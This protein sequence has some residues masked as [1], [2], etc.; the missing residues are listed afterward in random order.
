MPSPLIYIEDLHF[1][2]PVV[3]GETRAAPALRGINLTVE[4][5]ECVAIMGATGAGKSTLCLALNGL[6]P[7]STGGTFRGNVW[8]NGHNTC[9]EPVAALATQVGL[10]F[11]EAED[12]LCTMRVEDEIA[13]GLENLGLPPDEI[14]RRITWALD[15]VAMNDLRHHPPAQLS[16]G[17]Q[18]R[19]AL[20]AVLAM[21]PAVLVLDEPTAGLDPIGRRGVLDVVAAL[22]RQGSTIL[23]ATQD[24]EAAATLAD[25]VVV[26]HEGAIVLEGTPR[27]VFARV[28]QL[29]EWGVAVPQLSA[30]SHRLWCPTPWMT[31]QEAVQG[32][33]EHPALMAALRGGT[34][35]DAPQHAGNALAEVATRFENVWY[36]YESG[37]QA[38]QAIDLTLSV[39][40]Y[41]A[42]IGANGSG[43]STLARHISGLLRPQVGRVVVAGLDTRHTPPGALARYVGY[44][45]QNP[46][47]QIFSATVHEEVAFGPRNLGLSETQ[48]RARVA[49][50]LEQFQLSALADVPP[51]M[52]SFGQ[53]RLVTLASVHAMQPRVLVL[54]E[55]TS[56]LDDKLI[57]SLVEWVSQCHQAGSTVLFITHE[58]ALA[59]RAARCLVMQDGQIALDAPP[60]QVFAQAEELARVGL[61]PPP[62]V[63]LGLQLGLH[64]LPLTVE[65]FHR[66]LERAGQHAMQEREISGRE[67]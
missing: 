61:A 8:V 9:T 17:Q 21:Q 27:E 52:L 34:A 15:A 66:L 10:V 60:A 12:Q 32:L 39:G 43:K 19:L 62:V 47:H 36:R 38:L 11:Q 24:A 7:Q 26:L 54:D 55:P 14:E 53:R 40:E 1:A 13:F 46:D 42:L 4:A 33:Q 29:L 41:V 64:P 2:Y 57:R 37:V 45:F 28:P 5:G 50:A 56:G 44:V 30:L 23:M 59:A 65:A 31:V 48:V 58:M 49:E 20:A 16:G 51:A 35:V 63:T 6:V 3:R 67:V 25:R 18:R 22:G